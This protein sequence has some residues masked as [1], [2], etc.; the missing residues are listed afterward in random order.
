MKKNVKLELAS[1]EI[2]P[3]VWMIGGYIANDFFRKPPSSNVYILKD[4]NTI[5][6]LD[7]GKYKCYKKKIIELVN[8][9]KEKGV[10][11]VVLL[12]TQGHFDHDT[13]NDVVLNTSLPWEFYLPEEE[14]PTMK[15]VD[16]FMKDI[17]L[18][19]KY[20]NVFQTMFPKSGLS[21]IFRGIAKISPNTAKTLL[22]LLIKVSMG[23]SNH[24]ADKA[25][26]LKAA[27]RIK[28]DFG[29]VSLYG[30]ELGRFFIVFDGAHSPGHICIYDPINKLVLSGDTTVE[31]NPAFC[32]SSLNRLIDITG[33]FETMADEGYIEYAADSHRSNKYMSAFIKSFNTKAV[34]DIQLTEYAK[35]G[36]ECKNL[37]HFFNEYY[38]E[39]KREVILAHSKIGR[40]T[41]GQ[42]VD[43]LL[44]SNNKYIKFKAALIFP[45]A[46]SR[47]DVLVVQTLIEEGAAPIKVGNKIFIDPV[48]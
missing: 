40:A 41:V 16:D 43:E 15:S 25:I 34:N 19:S 44:K 10:N 26:I 9:Y 13:N 11:K 21:A 1:K 37:F 5:Y 2:L 32:Y 46:P 47:M 24:L 8:M 33:K 17:E 31:V 38:R 45:Q 48:K 39:M 35:T 7:P 22:K 12:I 28:K 6:I 42:I 4:K 3:D 23:T 27:Q 30:W 36:V 18:L 20:E 14:V 29:S